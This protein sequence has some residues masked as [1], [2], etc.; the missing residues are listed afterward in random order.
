MEKKE[1]INEI[2]KEAKKQ[3]SKKLNLQKK[4]LS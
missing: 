2:K 1:L 3:A 4:K